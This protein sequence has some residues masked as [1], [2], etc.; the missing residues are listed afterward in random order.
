M[1]DS[2]ETLVGVVLRV[3]QM[4]GSSVSLTDLAQLLPTDTTSKD[5]A[6]AFESHPRLSGRYV[7]RDGL[8]VHRASAHPFVDDYDERQSKSVANIRAARWLST[9]LGRKQALAIAVSG[10]T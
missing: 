7:L 1:T 10:S 2:F 8:V 3:A 6:S 4:H 9:K 5:L